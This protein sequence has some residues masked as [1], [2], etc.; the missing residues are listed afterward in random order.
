MLAIA[1]SRQANMAA[2]KAA[3]QPSNF[4]SAWLVAGT[5]RRAMDPA[6]T[7]ISAVERKSQGQFAIA[8]IDEA[9]VGPTENASPTIIA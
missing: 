4:L 1:K 6:H 7:A 2:H 3:D 9:T 8:R 5:P